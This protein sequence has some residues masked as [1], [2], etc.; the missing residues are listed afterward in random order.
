MATHTK[1]QIVAVL[2]RARGPEVAESLAAQLPE[3]VDLD[4]PKDQDL[5]ARH[6]LTR[7]GLL[8]ELG[9]EL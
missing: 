4:D 6:G 7:D 2:R 5:L 1:A 8:N 9:G 3:V